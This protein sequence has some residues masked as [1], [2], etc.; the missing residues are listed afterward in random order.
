[1]E[2]NQDTIYNF[3]KIIN[4]EL[5]YGVFLYERAVRKEFGNHISTQLFESPYSVTLTLLKLL[6]Y[7]IQRANTK[8]D[9]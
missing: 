9:A 5:A 1:M 3:R 6:K 2:F 4:D 8:E 7:Y